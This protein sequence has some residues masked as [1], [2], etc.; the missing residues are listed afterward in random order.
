LASKYPF[1]TPYQYAGNDPINFIDLDGKEQAQPE[2]GT[3][4]AEA[5]PPA[6][7]AN[8]NAVRQ[9]FLNFLGEQKTANAAKAAE[10]AKPAG[11]K[12][13]ETLGKAL[14][15]NTI[16]KIDNTEVDLTLSKLPSDPLAPAPLTPESMTKNQGTLRVPSVTDRMSN[17]EK[18][19]VTDPLIQGAAAGVLATGAITTGAPLLQG[20]V[21]TRVAS[22]IADVA[23][24]ATSIESIDDYN[25]TATVA[26]VAMPG[27][28]Y[29]QAALA[30]FGEITIGDIRS[31][32]NDLLGSTVFGDK[33]LTEAIART[34]VEGS[35]NRLGDKGDSFMKANGLGKS[36]S[37]RFFSGV[38]SN[39]IT[40]QGTVISEKLFDS[41]QQTFRNDSTK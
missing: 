20:T 28:N 39:F 34:G 11:Q 24:Q 18:Q 41:Y 10:A 21:S 38:T 31:E 32:D 40:N 15:E 6:G 22:G 26:A 35:F 23:S 16:G 27:S 19:L 7:D 33:S 17:F 13:D 30:N 37:G 5:K 25:V 4:T 1:Y 36:E 3:S 12:A 2:G 8:L 29:G 14:S 9:D